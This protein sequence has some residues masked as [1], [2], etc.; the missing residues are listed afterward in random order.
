MNTGDRLQNRFNQLR[1]Q[2]LKSRTRL[3]R[4]RELNR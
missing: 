2:G 3:G 4:F 1:E